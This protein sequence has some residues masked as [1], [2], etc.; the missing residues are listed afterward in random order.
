MPPGDINA[1]GGPILYLCI[2][3]I[4]LLL[5]IVWIEGDI[6]LFRRGP[7][8][9]A[10]ASTKTPWKDGN[11]MEMVPL[12][13]EVAAEKH[14]VEAAS[15]DLV[16]V[17]NVS[18]SFGSTHAVQ[19][20]TFGVPAGD[21]MALLGP[22]GAGKSTLVNMMQ[23]ELAPDH[24]QVLLHSGDARTRSAQRHLGVC[25]QF[26]ALDLMTTREHLDFYARVKGIRNVRANVDSIMARLDLSRHART[27][28]SKLS[29]GNK[30]KL[31]LAIALLG[32]PP[33]MVLD[34]PTSAMDAVAKRSFWR[35]I[36]DVGAAPGR[37]V[38]LTTHSMEE[39]D[40]LATRA[41]IIAGG[42][43]LAVGT[44]EALRERYSKDHHVSLLL[45]SAP[46]STA[47]EMAGVREWVQDRIRGAR[48][49]R[50]MLGGQVR[51]TVSGSVPALI[52]LL[53]RDKDGLGI[54]YYS[55]AGATLENVF[56][57][58]ARENN[59]QEEDGVVRGGLLR[60]LFRV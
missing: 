54:A 52:E 29:G 43:L 47:E 60:R 21:V 24:G 53:E 8:K 41:A 58:V 3:I 56:L 17:L 14:R 39:A 16:R 37:S 19:N 31:S 13:A 1:Y 23:A 30:R 57:S 25:P 27:N 46:A 49:E 22:N 11:K 55:V 59:A 6:A 38:L 48:L 42:R 36:R 18:K 35:L 34:E 51:F 40:A 20:V 44:T 15:T 28:A 12:S 9:A 4:V 33:V 45:R 50:A 5:V 26:D 7:N 32:A 10:A 2:Q